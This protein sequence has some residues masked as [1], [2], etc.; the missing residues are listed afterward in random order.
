MHVWKVVGKTKQSVWKAYSY[1]IE[2][3]QKYARGIVQFY[4][5]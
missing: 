4:E 5:T 2:S 1:I 3:F